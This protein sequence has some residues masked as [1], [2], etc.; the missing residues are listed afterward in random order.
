MILIVDFGSQYSQ[1][2]VRRFRNMG[3]YS[4]LC[5]PDEVQ[6]Y[7]K[8]YNPS[9]IVLSGGPADIYEKNAPFI[10]LKKIDVGI[11]ILGICY[12]MHLIARWFGGKIEC[13][14]VGEYGFTKIRLE[15]ESLLFNDCPKEFI[16]WM[17]HRNSV[18]GIPK[19]FEL[20]SLSESNHIAAMQHK[21]RE[22]YALQF[23]PEVKHTEYGLQI[24]KNFAFEMCKEK[25]NWSMKDFIKKEIKEIREKVGNKKV[26]CA[27]SGGVDSTVMAVF[28]NKAIGD[29]L[30]CIFV[31]NGLLRKNE[32]EEV[33][34]RFKLLGIKIN[35]I[36]A[37]EK[38]LTALKGI[39]DPEEKRKIIGKI[40]LDI[41]EEVSADY[42]FLAQGT[43]YPDVIES[44][45]F[46]GPSATIKTHHNRVEGIFTF[47][48]KGKVIEPLKELF[49]DEVRELG[50]ELGL[51]HEIL[52]RH[53]FPGP[54][55]GIRIIGEITKEKLNMLR[56]ADAI[57]ID[58]LKK[59][60]WYYKVW[61]AFVVL[62]PVKS[63]GVMGD[64]RTYE[65]TAVI[66]VVES[67]DGMTADWVKLPYEIL[68]KISNR[69]VNEVR[70]INRVVYDISS[71][72]PATI[73]WE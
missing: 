64:T 36:D 52:W 25:S 24:L 34:K 56:E 67:M 70:G 14:K 71:K 28:L 8:R 53:P 58:E 51:P 7:I 37:A 47:I 20:L 18:V 17:S 3:V 43:L 15:K 48:K 69:I 11:P 63:V 9:G 22:I 29:N 50:K 12:G 42:D 66:R 2:I 39:T 40:F 44:V 60:N 57:L 33:L 62:L 59:N 38:F 21:E 26:I 49:K 35:Y 19:D 65:Y 61:Q 68:G 27:V 1:L 46:K 23:H 41:F 55:L 31:N 73:E 6:K 16:V 10:E 45:N 30:T 72:P 4:L 5:A 13:A 32:S 54:G